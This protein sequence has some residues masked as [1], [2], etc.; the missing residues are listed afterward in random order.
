MIAV[1]SL[2]VGGDDPLS[3]PRP[4]RPTLPAGLVAEAQVRFT[5]K[6]V[7]RLLELYGHL[8]GPLGPAAG[9][10]E[11]LGGTSAGRVKRVNPEPVD[12]RRA[13]RRADIDRALKWLHVHH[14]LFWRP[15]VQLYCEPWPGE[16]AG[17]D[18]DS[19]R[20]LR[21]ERLA[22]DLTTTPKE[23]NR[24]VSLGVRGM[25]AFL[26]GEEFDP[27]PSWDQ[28]ARFWRELEGE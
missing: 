1:L 15:L 5:T 28:R 18:P 17:I 25:T 6:E 24:R 22:R 3:P 4:L 23:I 20:T 14:A 19:A 12:V 16:P 10:T 11:Y 2:T 8:R 13:I 26:N 21:V 9:R 27:H 7:Y